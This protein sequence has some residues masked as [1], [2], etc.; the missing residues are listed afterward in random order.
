MSSIH[1]QNTYHLSHQY[2]NIKSRAPEILGDFYA[3]TSIYRFNDQER[4]LTF[5][6]ERLI[7][8]VASGR[9]RVLLLSSNPHPHYIQ[10]EL[11]AYPSY[12][13]LLCRHN[14]QPL[15]TNFGGKI[16]S[17]LEDSK[18]LRSP[19]GQINGWGRKWLP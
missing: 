18:L 9:K 3:D 10:A 13:A 6:S 8:A 17:I 5:T 11:L 16:A 1:F 14:N 15:L 4:T 2:D 12:K 19:S 7:P